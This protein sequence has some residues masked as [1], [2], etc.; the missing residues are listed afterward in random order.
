MDQTIALES[1]TL[2]RTLWRRRTSEEI[3]ADIP[4]EVRE[5]RRVIREGGDPGPMPIDRFVYFGSKIHQELVK[6]RPD[7]KGLVPPDFDVDRPGDLK[8][9]EGS[10]ILGPMP[11]EM[12][13][14]RTNFGE[15]FVRP[16]DLALIP[17]H[18]WVTKSGVQV[19]TGAHGDECCCVPCCCEEPEPTMFF[20]PVQDDC[21]PECVPEDL[22]REWDSK[23]NDGPEGDLLCGETLGQFVWDMGATRRTLKVRNNCLELWV[24]EG[25]AP[26]VMEFRSPR[27][28]GSVSSR[29]DVRIYKMPLPHGSRMTR[30]PI[31]GGLLLAYLPDCVRPKTVQLYRC[32]LFRVCYCDGEVRDLTDECSPFWRFDRGEPSRQPY[33]EFTQN[34]IPQLANPRHLPPGEVSGK[35]W[36]HFDSPGIT[37]RGIEEELV[38]AKARGRS[39][40]AVV[41]QVDFLTFFYCNNTL[42]GYLSWCFRITKR[43]VCP[44]APT[45]I[46]VDT[47]LM[48]SEKWT[49]SEDI[50]SPDSALRAFDEANRNIPDATSRFPLDPG[51]SAGARVRGP[52]DIWTGN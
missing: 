11:Q 12:P 14:V 52:V 33:P 7:F 2:P 8:S 29:R 37:E 6:N 31:Y 5:A 21:G 19:I 50:V 23:L 30:D 39:V 22:E 51:S 45:P 47:T 49:D 38:L 46:A 28:S 16:Q 18:Q 34:N 27:T 26:R 44:L 32:E 48:C 36:I 4:H 25:A 1:P 20:R 15:V 41:R 10:L 43:F 24:Q 40:C 17:Q 9:I 3:L 42:I 13:K 35:G